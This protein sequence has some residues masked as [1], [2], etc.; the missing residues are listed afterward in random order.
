[1]FPAMNGGTVVSPRAL[2]VRFGEAVG[3]VPGVDWLFG[4]EESDPWVKTHVIIRP[5]IGCLAIHILPFSWR[6]NSNAVR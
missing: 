4:L 1:M 3:K 2:H 6:A 5:P